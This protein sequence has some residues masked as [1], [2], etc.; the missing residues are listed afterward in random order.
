MG[1]GQYLYIAVFEAEKTGLGLKVTITKLLQ[2][3]LL[4]SIPKPKDYWSQWLH[5]WIDS[6]DVMEILL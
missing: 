2:T 1:E 4:I 3:I 5:S 6:T